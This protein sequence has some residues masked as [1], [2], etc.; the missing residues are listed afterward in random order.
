MILL[1]VVIYITFISLGLPDSL[2]G[3]AWPVMHIDLG[4][5]ESFASIFSIIVAV[6]SGATSFIAGPLLRKF[7]TWKV[8]TVSV[9]LTAVG[10]IG[11]SYSPNIY[12]L[13]LF[14]IMMGIGAGAIDT[15]LNAFVAKH[16]KASHMNWL[17][18]FWGV[19][20][21]VSPIIM[22]T[23]LANGSWRGGYLTVACIQFGIAAIVL[24]SF[25]LWKR[26]DKKPEVEGVEEADAATAE[27][28]VPTEQ[29]V[30]ETAEVTKKEKPAV[31]KILKMRGVI[32]AMI[33]LGLYSGMEFLIG[34]WGASYAVNVKAVSPALA[35]KWVSLYYGGIMIGRAISGFLAMK[36]SDRQMILLG[37]L[38]AIP[39]MIV[40][41]LPIGEY[42]L[43]GLLMIGI[44]FG[45]IFPSTIH[46]TPTRFGAEYSA[47]I[48]GFQMGA[49]YAIGWAV[50][51]SFGYIATSTTFSFMPY[52]LLGVC[53]LLICTTEILNRITSKRTIKEKI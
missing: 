41:A 20:V 15:G 35:A 53:L 24:S 45:P 31:F 49:G 16:Y 26:F 47:D 36:L 32:L 29:P 9:L 4:L 14:S 25:K 8:T 46:A 30:Q 18:C 34:T 27:D 33:S 2:F 51:L 40:L 38:I 7:G 50:Q 3:V 39:G 44:G 1:L 11:I 37:E 52:E 23:F 12:V 10:M 43:I 19:G 5:N 48:T 6:G 28:N 17:H 42:V 22:S 21:T 13:I